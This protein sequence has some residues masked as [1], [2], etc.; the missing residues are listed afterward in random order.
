MV[1]LVADQT[2]LASDLPLH[3]CYRSLRIHLGVVHHITNH[4]NNLILGR[5]HEQYELELVGNNVVL[6]YPVRVIVPDQ[7]VVMLSLQLF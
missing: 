2:I 6:E 7:V 3:V 4:R 1:R 5:G